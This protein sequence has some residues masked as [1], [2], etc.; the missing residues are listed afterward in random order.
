MPDMISGLNNLQLTTNPNCMGAGVRDGSFRGK[1]DVRGGN[2]RLP[3]E[4][5]ICINSWNHCCR[6]LPRD[7]IQRIYTA[8]RGLYCGTLLVCASQSGV[9]SKR[10]NESSTWR[11]LQGANLPRILASENYI[12][13]AIA[14][15]IRVILCLA[16]SVELRLVTD[17]Q[18]DGWTHDSIHL[19]SIASRSKTRL[20]G[21]RRTL[22]GIVAK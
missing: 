15:R 20:R 7:E 3:T 22:F 8:Q 14:R 19:A 6:F 17:R 11:P 10:L 9:V 13:W 16:V 1:A 2:A 4:T 18:T 12:P 21:Q 5:G